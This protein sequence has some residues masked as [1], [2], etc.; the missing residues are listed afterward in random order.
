VGK[1]VSRSEK[2]WAEEF[3]LKNWIQKGRTYKVKAYLYRE[4]KE[5]KTGGGRNGLGG[6]ED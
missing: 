1:G 3:G 4:K 2:A 6:G 5:E